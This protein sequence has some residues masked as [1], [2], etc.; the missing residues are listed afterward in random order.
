[1]TNDSL[2]I[3]KQ[4]Q[5]ILAWLENEWWDRGSPVVYMLQ[6]FPGVGK[7]H[8][9]ESL[10]TQLLK[11]SPAIHTA[12]CEFPEGGGVDELIGTLQDPLK[13]IGVI[14][15]RRRS[16]TATELTKEVRNN[17]LLIAIDSFEKSLHKDSHQPPID[18]QEWLR[19][20]GGDQSLQ[21]RFLCLSS[22]EIVDSDWNERCKRVKLVGFSAQD[23]AR[24]LGMRMRAEGVDSAGLPDE[25]RQDVANWLGGLPR[26][27]NLLVGLIGNGANLDDLINAAPEAW[28]ARDTPAYQLRE[29]V[30]SMMVKKAC[31]GLPDKIVSFLNRIAIFRTPVHKSAFDKI[32]MG[33][34][35]DEYLRELQRRFLVECREGLWSMHP[36]LRKILISKFLKLEKQEQSDAHKKAAQYFAGHFNSPDSRKGPASMG[37]IYFEARYHCKHAHDHRLLSRLASRF[38]EFYREKLYYNTHIPENEGVRDENIAILSSLIEIGDKSPNIYCHLARLLCSRNHNGDLEKAVRYAVSGTSAHSPGQDWQLRLKLLVRSDGAA[39]AVEDA[40]SYGLRQLRSGYY[41][42]Y[43]LSKDVAKLLVAT[44]EEQRIRDAFEVLQKGL[45]GLD[46]DK[47]R[48]YMRRDNLPGW[49]IDAANILAASQSIVGTEL[50]VRIL[51]DGINFAPF[52]SS[53]YRKSAELLAS[54]K[55]SKDVDAAIGLLEVGIRKASAASLA[56]LYEEAAYLLA[57]SKVPTDVDGAIKLLKEGIQ[58]VPPESNLG[59]LYEKAADLLA[60]SKVPRDVVD[61]INLLREGIQKVPEG[62]LIPLY[63]LAAKLLA[64]SGATKDIDEVISLLKAGIRRVPSEFNVI[65]LHLRAAELLASSIELKDI[66]DAIE[67]LEDGK[68]RNPSDKSSCSKADTELVKLRTNS[69]W[70]YAV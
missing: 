42:L 7:T 12:Y 21:G 53:L 44:D 24:Y 13:E 29:A 45:Q 52:D 2:L 14:G 67:L 46:V 36:V 28:E 38:A 4:H 61:A 9:R 27:M 39:R 30:E 11:K 22:H 34:S 15:V 6:G 35:K 54:S 33:G 65:A 57:N 41:D 10:A 63:L 3:G 51:A 60:G 25:R 31:D 32:M 50:A 48:Y 58:K 16:L 66:E 49:Y 40:Q 19:R 68:R 62:S 26:A 59:S 23:G 20:T 18:L 1:M 69:P 37:T 64:S 5:E 17:Q 70:I 8:I 43:S 55:V 47:D 56:P